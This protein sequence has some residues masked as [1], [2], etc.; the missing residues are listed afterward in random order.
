MDRQRLS[1][2]LPALKSTLAP[3]SASFGRRVIY[4]CLLMCFDPLPSPP[5]SFMRL[6]SFVDWIPA[7]NCTRLF[8]DPVNKIQVSVRTLLT[9]RRQV[10]DPTGGHKS[11]SSPL[12][13][14]LFACVAKRA[15]RGAR[16]KRKRLVTFRS[17]P[18]PLSSPFPLSSL[19][20]L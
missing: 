14:K 11:A 12:S 7:A 3:I 2:M 5:P 6:F 9:P 8:G 10:F 13:G 1:Q 16:R 18:S 19:L 15:V 17:P 4:T 20:F